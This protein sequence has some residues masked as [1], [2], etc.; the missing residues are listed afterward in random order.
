MGHPVDNDTNAA[1]LWNHS[2]PSHLILTRCMLRWRNNR[3]TKCR[4]IALKKSLPSH[5]VLYNT[6]T[7][8]LKTNSNDFY[9]DIFTKSKL[10][11]G[12]PC[13]ELGLRL[14]YTCAGLTAVR[15]GISPSRS[16]RPGISPSRSVRPGI[17]PSRS[18]RP[19]ISPSRW[20]LVTQYPP[21]PLDLLHTV[22]HP[23]MSFSDWKTDGG[24]WS[25]D[26]FHGEGYRKEQR[27]ALY[28]YIF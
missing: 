6:V 1:H 9:Q 3:V 23:T 12:R 17:S 20:T 4:N 10:S 21:F 11:K 8:V 5:K 28:S 14:I 18:V 15:P 26:T 27:G 2:R 7:N 13:L 22:H 24:E 16:V 19:G 25:E